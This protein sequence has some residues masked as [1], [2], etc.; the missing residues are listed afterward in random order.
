MN[1][2]T[3]ELALIIKQ[4]LSGEHI[5]DEMAMEACDV[6]EVIENE[7]H[8]EH[9]LTWDEVGFTVG[10]KPFDLASEITPSVWNKYMPNDGTPVSEYRLRLQGFQKMSDSRREQTQELRIEVF[11]LNRK[12]QRIRVLRQSGGDLVL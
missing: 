12:P 7:D 2:L 1:V 9:M 4:S 8:T 11:G 3:P 5:L 6:L 10:D